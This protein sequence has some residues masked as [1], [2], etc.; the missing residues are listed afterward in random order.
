MMCMIFRLARLVDAVWT[1]RRTR[2]AGLIT[3]QKDRRSWA[4]PHSSSFYLPAI[5]APH[6]VEEYIPAGTWAFVR[7]LCEYDGV[8]ADCLTQVE[9]K[10]TPFG[11]ETLAKVV[12]FMN[13]RTALPV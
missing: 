6:P 8:L 9:D 4:S 3:R 11:K 7:N 2:R 10:L 5:M 1:G 12:E 13:V